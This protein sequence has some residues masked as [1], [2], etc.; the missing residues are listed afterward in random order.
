MSKNKAI[1]LLSG[2][3]DSILAVKILQAQDLEV[4]GISFVSNFYNAEKAIVAAENLNI[5]HHII[6]IREEMLNLVKNPPS[7]YGKNMNPCIDCHAQMLRLTKEKYGQDFSI[8]ATGEVLGQRP[9]SQNKEALLRVQKLAGFEILRPLCAK[10]LP[11]TSMEKDGLVNRGRLL[12]IFGRTRDRQFE[13]AKKYNITDFPSPAGGCLLTDPEFSQRLIKLLDNVPNCKHDDIELLKHG[14]IFWI[15]NKNGSKTLIVV[16]RN[17]NDN[18][19]LARLK[20]QDCLFVELIDIMGP[21][22]LIKFFGEKPENIKQI[23][24]LDI[25]EKLTEI[26][27]KLLGRQNEKEIINITGLLTGYYSAKARGQRIKITVFS[28]EKN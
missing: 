5:K 3:L 17:S 28:P 23:I 2:G 25:P 6:D 8:I 19:H 18:E 26:E 24:E 11:E 10:L 15:N 14:R 21:S 7:G 1:V 13:L 22:S 20:G 9:F 12:D 27:A 16:G 4:E